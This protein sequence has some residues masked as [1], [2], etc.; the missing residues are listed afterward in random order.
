MISFRTEINPD[1]SGFRISHETK[2]LFTGS[3]FA[4]NI[5][6]YLK[7]NLFPVRINPFGVVYNPISVLN[8]LGILLDGETFTED[9][10]EFYDEF[11]FSWD[12]HSSFSH[13]E[14]DKC[15]AKINLEIESSS[16][17]LKE[18]R[19]LLITFGT[20]W[21]YR[22]KETG[23]VVSNCHK[24]PDSSFD[25]I[26]LKPDGIILAWENFLDEI[27]TLNPDLKVIFTVSPVR[28]WKE[29]A[30]G[31]QL[32]KAALLLAVDELC[33]KF[34]EKTEYFPAYELLLDDLRDYRFYAD[35]LL[36]PGTQA[37]EYIQVKFGQTYFDGKTM[38]LIKEIRKLIQAKNHS[39]FNENSDSYKKFKAAQ[40]KSVS[41]LSAIYPFLDLT[42][43]RKH[44]S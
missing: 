6:S 42:E 23:K 9:D 34:P 30:H 36:H 25:R 28:H 11:W 24:V 33:G 26:L 40:V 35:D 31:N 1:P 39:V 18:S 13:A 14:K 10:L 20:A 3:C 19:F 44:F 41:N 5:G 21:V 32:S 2:T 8:T 29:G 38:E 17:H 7:E 4:D 22:L 27:F 43:F 12:H 37:L 16:K 15:L